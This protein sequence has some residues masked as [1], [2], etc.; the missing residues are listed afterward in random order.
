[1]VPRL[2]PDA[3]KPSR[4]RVMTVKAAPTFTM[5]MVGKF[6]KSGVMMALNKRVEETFTKASLR[7]IVGVLK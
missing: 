7:K 1:M 6:S 5:M 2:R 4:T 3:R